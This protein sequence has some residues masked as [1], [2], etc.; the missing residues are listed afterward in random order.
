MFKREKDVFSWT[1]KFI[2]S[3]CF[4]QNLFVDDG[5]GGNSLTEFMIWLIL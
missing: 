5:G 2:E 1:R 3:Q 4:M